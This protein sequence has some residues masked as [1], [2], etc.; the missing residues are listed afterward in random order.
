MPIRYS[1][2]RSEGAKITNPNGL[3]ISRVRCGLINV[4]PLE[5]ASKKWS[6]DTKV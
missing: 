4:F 1:A 5:R 3:V 2:H 6:K